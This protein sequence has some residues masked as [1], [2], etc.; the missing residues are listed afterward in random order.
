MSSQLL[1]PVIV[2]VFKKSLAELMTNRIYY[3]AYYEH[4]ISMAEKGK[5]NPVDIQLV[6]EVL[7]RHFKKRER[8]LGLFYQ[9]VGQCRIQN[10]VREY[11]GVLL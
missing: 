3:Y 5:V 10:I 4:N 6:N 11:I 9:Y 8:D 2:R 7:K 1:I